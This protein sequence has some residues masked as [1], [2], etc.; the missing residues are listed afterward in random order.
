ME[1]QD[2]GIVPREHAVQHECVDVEVKIEAPPE[3]LDHGHGAPATIG[4]IVQ[5]RSAPQPAEHGT[6]IDS[7]DGAAQV[8]VP[9]QLVTQAVGQAQHPL[10]DWNIGKHVVHQMRGAL[11][12]SAA[13]ATRAKAAPFAREGY[14]TIEPAVAAAKPREP[15]S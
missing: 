14:Q 9:R 5:A 10:P 4:H 13:T 11:G 8:V 6:H 3:P 15:A 1:A 7:D 12:H 2:T